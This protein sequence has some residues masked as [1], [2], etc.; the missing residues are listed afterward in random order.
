M[1]RPQIG[2]EVFEFVSNLIPHRSSL[3]RLS[4]LIDWPSLDRRLVDI[5]S[6]NKGERAWPPTA[7]FRTLLLAVWYDGLASEQILLANSLCWDGSHHELGE[8]G[9]TRSCERRTAEPSP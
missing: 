1:A 9:L 5:Y 2:Q 3:D 6:A 7:L 4:E 8:C